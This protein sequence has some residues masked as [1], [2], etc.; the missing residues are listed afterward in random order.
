MLHL[1]QASNPFCIRYQ[2]QSTACESQIQGG[3]PLPTNNHFLLYDLDVTSNQL[4]TSSQWHTKWHHCICD[5]MASYVTPWDARL[6]PQHV[7]PHVCPHPGSHWKR[8]VWC[9]CRC[10]RV[11]QI[12]V[13]SVPFDT[14]GVGTSILYQSGK[15]D[16]SCV[17]HVKRVQRIRPLYT[18]HYHPVT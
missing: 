7:L 8:W 15:S 2:Q 1:T 11:A 14:Q 16:T 17:L 9:R 4:M 6:C 12:K 3:Q 5:V 18:P 13:A 10:G